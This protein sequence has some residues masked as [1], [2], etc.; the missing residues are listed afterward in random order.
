QTRRQGVEVS[1]TGG[2]RLQWFVNYTALD[3]TFRENF[4]VTSPNHPSAA[5]GVIAV[6]TGDRLPLVPK[7]LLKGGLSV[8]LGERLRLSG[9]VLAGSGAPLRGDEGNLLE[10]LDGYALLSLRA[11]YRLGAH[12]ELFLNVDNALDEEY[13]TFG[14][15]GDAEDVL[16]DDFDDPRFVSPGAPRAAWVGVRM[17]F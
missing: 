15:L 11:Q 3:A 7:S 2:N 9:D 17:R 1:L 12:A 6:E 4:T 13:A 10:P 8:S 14:V 16:G 5:G